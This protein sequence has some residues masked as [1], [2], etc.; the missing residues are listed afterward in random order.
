MAFAPVLT[1]RASRSGRRGPSPA[2][3]AFRTVRHATCLC[4][5]VV[6]NLQQVIKAGEERGGVGGRETEPAT[7]RGC[8]GQGV[9]VSPPIFPRLSTKLST[10]GSGCFA[11]AGC[12][13]RTAY[14]ARPRDRA[15]GAGARP[16]AAKPPTPLRRVRPTEVVR[17]LLRP[18]HHPRAVG[19]APAAAR[20]PDGALAPAGS[21]W[22]SRRGPPRPGDAQ[23]GA[24]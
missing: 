24:G 5:R 2:L 19:L 7:K 10:S 8:N 22:A 15:G 6:L 16:Q 13:V 18:P 3:P 12:P 1:A 4:A 11:L 21:S 23:L 20:A 9:G 17:S 14:G